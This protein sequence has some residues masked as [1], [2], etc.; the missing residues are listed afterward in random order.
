MS[1][2][3][4]LFWV[5]KTRDSSSLSNCRNEKNTLSQIRSHTLSV[6]HK[7]NRVKR[8][9]N[10]TPLDLSWTRRNITRGPIGDL[11]FQASTQNHRDGNPLTDVG[12]QESENV[13]RERDSPSDTGRESIFGNALEINCLSGIPDPFLSCSI[14]LD[15]TALNHLWYFENI[16]TQCAFKL[17]ECVGY[18]QKPIEQYETT[19]MIQQY[20]ANK[21]HSY[22]LLAATGARI[23][24]IH[25]HQES[26]D[27]HSG[28]SM[29]HGYAAKAL[30]GVR[31]RIEEHGRIEFSEEDSTD[32]L[33]LAAY[34]IFCSNEIGA[35]QHLTAVRRVYK[36]EISN[37]FMKRL[38]VNLERLA[39]KPAAG[40]VRRLLSHTGSVTS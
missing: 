17:P 14:E 35:E 33:F 16:W 26:R 10:R 28:L 22:C 12:I 4:N 39:A 6:A 37:T 36:Q 7:S 5:N 1:A 21:T 3:S 25:H 34:E 8:P 20:L 30:R 11:L 32:I 27:G 24:Y 9:I 19:A 29:A 15:I 2:N 23:Q 13:Q 40:D 31:Q 18:G 38:Q